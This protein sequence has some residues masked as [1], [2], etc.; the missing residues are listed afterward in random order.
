MIEIQTPEARIKALEDQVRA[1]NGS[2]G[3]AIA[4]IATLE[5]Q[6]YNMGTV[7][8]FSG[9]GDPGAYAKEGDVWVPA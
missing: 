2:L 9:G 7:R 5:N 1:L 6:V 8:T 3:T 4:R